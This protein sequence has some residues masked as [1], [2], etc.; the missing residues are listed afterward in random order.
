[1]L[2][3]VLNVLE[4]GVLVLYLV[5]CTHPRRNKGDL[6]T[7]SRL[8]LPALVLHFQLP[9]RSSETYLGKDMDSFQ[10]RVANVESEGSQVN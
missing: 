9:N 6:R 5:I 8:C 1:M 10:V 2:D 4:M 7:H 3:A